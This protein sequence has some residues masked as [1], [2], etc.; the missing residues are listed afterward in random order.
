MRKIVICAI[1]SFLAACNG[2]TRRTPTLSAPPAAASQTAQPPKRDLL[3]E[4]GDATW[5]VV[6]VPAQLITPQKKAAPTPATM[7]A[8]P[9]VIFSQRSY[10]DDEPVAA[11]PKPSASAPATRP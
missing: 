4:A 6:T 7:Y 1:L 5:K 9:T 10:S 11:P 2:S 3:Q 8:P